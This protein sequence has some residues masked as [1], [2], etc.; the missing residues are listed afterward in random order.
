MQLFTNSIATLLLCGL[1]LVPCS[2]R[3]EQP[4]DISGQHKKEPV[5]SKIAPGVFRIG[6]IQIHK[7]TRSITFP[8]VVNMD[9]GL[10]EYLLVQS[11]GKTHESLLRTEVDPYFLNIAFLLLGFEGTDNPLIEQGA[12]QIPQGEPVE[13][14]II[15]HDSDNPEIAV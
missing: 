8:A 5:I 7:K 6:E 12:A 14:I 2:L 1:L 13:I 11:Q 10:L 3:A 4:L 9:K 15:Y